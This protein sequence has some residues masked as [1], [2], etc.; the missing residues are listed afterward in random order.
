MIWR[1]KLFEV[2]EFHR[3]L[4]HFFA[5]IS[6]FFQ[7]LNFILFLRKSHLNYCCSQD[8]DFYIWI[9]TVQ[10]GRLFKLDDRQ[11]SCRIIR[12]P[13]YWLI[14]WLICYSFLHSSILMIFYSSTR[15]LIYW[16]TF[17]VGLKRARRSSPQA[18]KYSRLSPPLRCESQQK[19]GQPHGIH[20]PHHNPTADPVQRRR[21]A[22]QTVTKRH[23]ETRT[24][25]SIRRGDE[26]ASGPAHQRRPAGTTTQS[27]PLGVE[28]IRRVTG[29]QQ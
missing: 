27:S 21:G 12:G 5:L 11:I 20:H 24:T 26:L 29:Q 23:Q 3:D 22:G 18:L 16:L 28:R 8:F 17:F 6:I 9:C 13:F 4:D 2:S 14:D 1:E 10:Y 25:P 7:I 19:H 15:R